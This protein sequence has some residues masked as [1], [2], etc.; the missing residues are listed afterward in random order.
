M[1]LFALTDGAAA[2]AGIIGAMMLA[3]RFP[4]KSALFG[5]I[6]IAT[7]AFA[8]AIGTIKFSLNLFE[9][10]DPIHVRATEFGAIV[11]MLLVSVSLLGTVH[12]EFVD[13]IWSAVV[14]TVTLSIY[15]IG[16]I[17]QQITIISLLCS[18]LSLLVCLWTSF[19]LFRRHK[20]QSGLRG[21]LVALLMIIIG[22]VP[23]VIADPSLS[24]HVFHVMVAV[25]LLILARH[26]SDLTNAEP[27][28]L[29]ATA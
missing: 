25:W 3:R 22:A 27:H 7:M 29:W 4:D 16:Y 28:R 14:L 9:P 6:G 15:A 5:S 19:V 23:W 11:G 1:W 12:R 24:F 2:V 8:A 20:S 21:L 26:I 18:A 13:G 10:L 17:S